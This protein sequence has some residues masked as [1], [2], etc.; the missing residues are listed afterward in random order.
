MVVEV[1]VV[2]SGDGGVHS[3]KPTAHHPPQHHMSASLQQLGTVAGGRMEDLATDR[4]QSLG[5]PAVLNCHLRYNCFGP[6]A[7]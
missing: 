1:E 7:T 5:H 6:A 4:G 3:T 2:Q